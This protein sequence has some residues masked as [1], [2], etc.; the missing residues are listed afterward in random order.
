MELLL[1]KMMIMNKK[2]KILKTKS[3]RLVLDLRSQ[4]CNSNLPM[5]KMYF[6]SAGFQQKS[7]GFF[8]S[9]NT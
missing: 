4:N 7:M 2:K 6:L 1:K 8:E 3:L 5:K 9:R